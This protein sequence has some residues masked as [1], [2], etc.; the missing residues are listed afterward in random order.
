MTAWHATFVCA[1]SWHG[2]FWRLST[3]W[4][5]FLGYQKCVLL[6]LA[7][8]LGWLKQLHVGQLCHGALLQCK[9]LLRRSRKSFSRKYREPVTISL[10]SWIHSQPWSLQWLFY[11]WHTSSLQ[12]WSFRLWMVII[13]TLRCT[14]CRTVWWRRQ[15]P[16]TLCWSWD[17]VGTR[18]SRQHLATS[19]TFN[20]WRYCPTAPV[21]SSC[22]GLLFCGSMCVLLALAACLSDSQLWPR[23]MIGLGV[24]GVESKLQLSWRPPCRPSSSCASCVGRF[25]HSFSFLS[26][27]LQRLLGVRETMRLHCSE[28]LCLS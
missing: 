6:E 24:F 26:P 10:G 18:V 3:T 13:C 25:W 1:E 11:S 28:K 9:S 20:T 14:M 15:R 12:T 23:A 8:F 22:F 27:S 19:S 21:G 17:C 5:C 7:C 4:V 2:Q 16:H